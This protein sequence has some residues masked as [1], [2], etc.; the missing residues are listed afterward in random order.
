MLVRRGY[1]S[2]LAHDAIRGWERMRASP[3]SAARHDGVI[4]LY[5]RPGSAALAPHGALIAAGVEPE[6]LRVERDGDTVTPAD[7][8]SLNPMGVVPTLV[9]DDLVVTEAAAI[10]QYVADTWPDAE[11][12]PAVWNPRARPLQRA[13]RLPQHHAAEALLRFLYPERYTAAADPAGVKEAAALA[14]DRHF[15]WLEG[16]LAGQP[17][18]LGDRIAAVDFY[19]HMLIRWG[20]HLDPDARA[21]GALRLLRAAQPAPARGPCP[22][23][24][25]PRSL[26]RKDACQARPPVAGISLESYPPVNAVDL[27]AVRQKDEQNA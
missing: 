7:Y 10:V 24:A 25:R 5:F 21:R 8:L 9:H 11:L 23:A 18:L 22:R 2:E 17:T 13:A 1:G 15:D 12:A 4:R 19:L 6:L 16:L 14:L 20:R 27:A 3:P 26:G